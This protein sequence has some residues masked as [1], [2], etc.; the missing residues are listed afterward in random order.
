MQ[1]RGVLVFEPWLY[2]LFFAVHVLVVGCLV[3]YQCRLPY[4]DT[5][6][7]FDAAAMIVTFIC[8]GKYLEHLTK[9]RTSE[10]CCSTR[11]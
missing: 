6:T 4:A 2:L 8:L 5:M 3:S 1:V 10:V 11:R 9:G 7:F